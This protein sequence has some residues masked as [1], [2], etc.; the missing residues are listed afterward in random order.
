MFQRL[1]LKK[2]EIPASASRLTRLRSASTAQRAT[3]PNSPTGTKIFVDFRR[4]R[5]LYHLGQ[6]M[7]RMIFVMVDHVPLKTDTEYERLFNRINYCY[8]VNL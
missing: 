4:N 2:L 8:A 1:V 6:R 7:S 3:S 5:R